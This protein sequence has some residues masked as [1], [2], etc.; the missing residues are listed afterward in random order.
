MLVLEFTGDQ[1]SSQIVGGI[2]RSQ[3]TITSINKKLL[4]SKKDVV[5]NR[6]VTQQSEKR[7]KSRPSLIS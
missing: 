3:N 2:Q 5:V 1:N 7:K 4:L 6:Y